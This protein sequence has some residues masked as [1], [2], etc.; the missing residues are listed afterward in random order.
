MLTVKDELSQ[1][2]TLLKMEQEE[3]LEQYKLKS[4]KSPIAER[5]KSGLCWYPITI[6]KTEIGFGG[7]VVVEI[8]RQ[9]GRDQLHLFQTGKAASIFTNSHNDQGHNNNQLNGVIMILKRN[10]LTLATNKEDLPDWIEEGKL[11]IDLTFDEMSYK[12]MEFALKKVIETEG[13]RLAHLREVLYGTQPA[14]FKTNLH[15]RPIPH[16]NE[17]QNEAVKNIEAAKDVAIIHGPP[18]T[19][20]TTTLVQAVLRTLETESRLLVCA[21]SNTAVDLLTEKLAEQ[22]VNVIRIGHPSRVS[23][24]LLQHTLDAQI[25]N[26]REYKSLKLLRKNAE[27]YKS[28]AFQHKRKF[29]WEEREQRRLLKEE[30]RMML[31]EA[32]EIERYITDDLLSRVQVIT[33]T[34]VGSANRVIRHLTYDTVFIDEAAQALEPGC[35]IP[36]TRAN[37]VVL[38]G[39]HFQLPPTVKSEKA[40]RL[41]LSKTLFEKTIA[42]QPEVAVMLKTQYRMHHQIMNFSNKQFY[43]G[44]LKAHESVHFSDL[45]HFNPAFTEGLAVE[46]VD[47][48]GCGYNEQS[49]SETSSVANPEEADL[50]LKHLQQLLEQFPKTEGENG[51]E[52]PLKI[53]IISPY[54]AQIN[55]LKDQ[56]EQMPQLHELT[57]QKQL[58][59]GTVDSF[60][61]QERDIIYISMVRSNDRGEIGFLADIRRMNVGMTRAKKKLVIVGDSATLTYDPFYQEFVQYTED[62]GAYRSAW[63]FINV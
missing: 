51:T 41:G 15:F 38:A 22:G 19:G 17:S 13:T 58:S 25:M 59:V 62:I 54:R 46:Y 7:K 2:Q 30:S 33:C 57:V 10:K 8:E 35:W 37:R 24:M 42:R 11:G 4:A 44:E 16:L 34:L 53:G 60:Q 45:H 29:G 49:F 14:A 47:T 63:E 31:Q 32:D 40:D 61:G 5:K 12:E 52:K 18:G 21:P 28:M 50:L 55:Y 39:D 56:V 23:E 3:D 20:K 27:E 6:T 36:V 43:G 48:A 9:G 26:H 1:V